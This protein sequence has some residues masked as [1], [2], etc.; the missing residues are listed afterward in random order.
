MS[1]ESFRPSWGKRFHEETVHHPLDLRILKLAGDAY[2]VR[3]IGGGFVAANFENLMDRL[4]KKKH[5][6]PIVLL[7]LAKEMEGEKGE[8]RFTSWYLNS[9]QNDGLVWKIPLRQ[10]QVVEG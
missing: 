2:E 4:T 5:L 6:E 7:N 1:G 8:E 9:L 3:M 10:D